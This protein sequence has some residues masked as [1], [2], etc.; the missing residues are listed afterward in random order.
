MHKGAT[1]EF[2]LPFWTKI[3]GSDRSETLSVANSHRAFL[4]RKDY[5]PDGF[6]IAQTTKAA[7]H[8]LSKLPPIRP[9]KT[10]NNFK[11]FYQEL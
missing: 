7:S 1:C 6:D 11:K 8:E 9:A 10:Q 5:I 2:V 4:T 3:K